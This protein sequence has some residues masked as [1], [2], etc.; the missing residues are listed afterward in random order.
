[1]TC[2]YGDG[3]NL[4]GGAAVLQLWRTNCLLLTTSKWEAFTVVTGRP[5]QYNWEDTWTITSNFG[6]HESVYYVISKLQTSYYTLHY[7][8]YRSSASVEHDLAASKVYL[9]QYMYM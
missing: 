5:R 7:N 6:S 8:S 4:A 3:E 9:R 1:M 2:C